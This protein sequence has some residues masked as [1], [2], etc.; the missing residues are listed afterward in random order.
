MIS[1]VI[2]TLNAAETLPATLSALVPAAVTNLVREVVVADGGSTDETLEIVDDA[3]AKLIEGDLAAGLAVAK[4]P[5]LLILN[6]DVRLSSEWEAAARDHIEHHA[7]SAG[8]F[9][10]ALD[11]HRATARIAEAWSSLKGASAANG[12]LVSKRSYD[13]AGGDLD[14]LRNRM[15]PLAARAFRAG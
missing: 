4:G 5:W 9:R 11:D 14:K 10:L 15:R 13:E 3:G 8:Y 2:A 1:V 6:A 12:L 7:K